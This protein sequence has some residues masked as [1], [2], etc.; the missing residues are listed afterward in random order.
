MK[1]IEEQQYNACLKFIGGKLLDKLETNPDNKPLKQLLEALDFIAV[2]NN[3]LL[4]ELRTNE[5]ELN[6]LKSEYQR[7][8]EKVFDFKLGNV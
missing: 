3:Q 4:A 7:T 1:L 6:D 2:H 8:L 5:R